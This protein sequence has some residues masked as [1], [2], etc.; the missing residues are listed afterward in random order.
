MR[1]AVTGEER[2]HFARWNVAG[3]GKMTLAEFTAG[4]S[5]EQD[6]S[7]VRGTLDFIAE[8]HKFH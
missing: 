5:A 4:A 8:S 3:D 6:K 1:C 2:A 7:F